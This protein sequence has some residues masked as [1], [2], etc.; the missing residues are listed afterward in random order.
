VGFGAAVPKVSKQAFLTAVE[1]TH[2][3]QLRRFLA[4]RLRNAAADTPDLMQEVYLRLLR[5]A[6]HEAIR[7]PQA[8]LYTVA[9]HVL[10]QHTLRQSMT[11]EAAA[12]M[13]TAS[14][15][16]SVANSDPAVEAELDQVF[17]EL[18]R[19]LQTMSPK[20]YATLILSRCD[21]VPLKD[22]GERLG[23]SR[24]QVKK[25]LAKALIHVR[26]RLNE[27]SKDAP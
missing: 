5:V 6:D 10:H 11:P 4:A 3:Q 13:E 21:G 15:C 8:Y 7:N 19:S 20:A 18:G 12:L 26:Q 27:M 9:S 2:G 25:Y 22:I 1:K 14:E 24:D 23:I 16:Q 17:E